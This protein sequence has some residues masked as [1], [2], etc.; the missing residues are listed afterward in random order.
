MT[1]VDQSPSVAEVADRL[2]RVRARIAAAGGDDTVSVLAVTKGFGPAVVRTAVAA[3]LTELGENYAQE[4]V[5]KADALGDELAVRWHFIGQLQRNKVKLLAPHVAVWQTVDRL[6]V[7]EAI[8]ARVH[9]PVVMVQVAISDEPRKGGC[10]PDDVAVLVGELQRRG[11]EVRG[12]MAVGA[13]GP[14][15]A[16]RPGFRRLRRLAD[17]LG[18]RDVSMGMSGDL[19]VAVEEGSTMVRIGTALF[20]PRPARRRM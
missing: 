15:E 10:P 18:L 20:G 5:A 12:L 6:K 16:A 17:D 7:G 14:A 8:L 2:G 11:V 1:E 3:G 13:T 19:E 9:D 4:L